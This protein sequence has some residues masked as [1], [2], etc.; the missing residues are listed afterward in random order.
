MNVFYNY[1]SNLAND[2]TFSKVSNLSIPE[3]AVYLS[4]KF[5]SINFF[6]A[7]SPTTYKLLEEYDLKSS[8]F[9]TKQSSKYQENIDAIW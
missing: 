8:T 4:G 1:L 9:D 6:S 2:N 3:N 5:F 7:T